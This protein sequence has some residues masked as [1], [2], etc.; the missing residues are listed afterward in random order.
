MFRIYTNKYFVLCL[1]L[2]SERQRWVVA[3]A[4]AKVQG[5]HGVS[6]VQRSRSNSGMPS[7]SDTRLVRLFICS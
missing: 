2:S 5:R 4:S 7:N 6:P 1:S 3:L